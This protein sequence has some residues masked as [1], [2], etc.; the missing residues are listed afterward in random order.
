MTFNL[1]RRSV[2]KVAAASVATLAAP[3]VLRAK[4]FATKPVTIIVGN[5]AGGANDTLARLLQPVL[6]AELGKPVLV[7]NRPGAAGNLGLSLAMQAAPDGHTLFCSSSVMLATAHTHINSPGSP[8]EGLEHITMI[9]DGNFTYTAPTATGAKNYEEFRALV[10]GKPGEIRHGTPGAGGN[11]HLSAELLK[12]REKL[13][14]PAIHYKAAGDLITDL[15]SNQIQLAINAIQLTEPHIRSGK[16]VP[17][18]TAGKEREKRVEGVPTSVEL[19]IKDMERITNWFALHAPKGTPE[20]I[21]A[22][23]H[24]ASVKSIK[25]QPAVEKMTA[26]GWTPVGD[27]REAFTARL[28]SDDAIFGEVARETGI[29]I[30]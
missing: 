19:G 4:S 12:L 9:G 25:S 5:A 16:L 24:A 27:S 1:S 26:G 14:M 20:S 8:L 21:L 6:E 30:G 23:L 18:F 2:L 28:K 15:L 3:S 7:E 29:R 22:E 10:K 17:L 13:D 11:I